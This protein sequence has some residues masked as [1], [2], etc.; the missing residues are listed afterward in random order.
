VRVDL[1][2]LQDR[3]ASSSC[4]GLSIHDAAMQVVKDT[5]K[6]HSVLL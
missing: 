3:L 2:L 4:Q 6:T 1:V 5:Q